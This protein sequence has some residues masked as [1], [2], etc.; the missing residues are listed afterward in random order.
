MIYRIRSKSKENSGTRGSTIALGDLDRPNDFG[1]VGVDDADVASL[2]SQRPVLSPAL[3]TK[4]S[5][6]SSS[7][8]QQSKLG[9]RNAITREREFYVVRSS[10]NVKHNRDADDGLHK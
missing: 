5:I 7:S 1:Y 9:P 2:D 10:S 3:P 6:V 8:P 4:S